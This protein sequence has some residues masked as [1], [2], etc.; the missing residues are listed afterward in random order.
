MTAENP[1]QRSGLESLCD[2]FEA[3]LM[4]HGFRES[5]QPL[6]GGTDRVLRRGGVEIVCLTFDLD[7]PRVGVLDDIGPFDDEC[8]SAPIERDLRL[9]NRLEIGVYVPIVRL[10]RPLL[11]RQFGPYFAKCRSERIKYLR[12]KEDILIW[13]RLD[14]KSAIDRVLFLA[15]KGQAIWEKSPVS[16][17]SKPKT[18][19]Q[20][21]KNRLIKPR[22]K[23]IKLAS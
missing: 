3:A 20:S 16:L 10:L 9:G 14:L 23:K 22:V 15:E 17:R 6:I 11:S 13:T 4:A 8:Q 21:K 1:C 7:E 2:T 18:K 19:K 12:Q 5:L